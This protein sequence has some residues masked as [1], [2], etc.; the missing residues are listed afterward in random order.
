[1]QIAGV[2]MLHVPFRNSPDAIASVLGRQVDV[3]FD[4]V[5]P[6]IGHVQSGQLKALAVTGKDRFTPIP[7]V[8]TVIESGVVPG[9][10][11]TTWYGVFGPRGTPSAVTAKL[12]YTLNEILSEEAVRQ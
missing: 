6:L 10:D 7:D 2:K 9:Y 11:V 8:P 12:S 5:P 3:L 4:T 1:M